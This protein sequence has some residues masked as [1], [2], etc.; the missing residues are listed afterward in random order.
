METSHHLLDQSHGLPILS[1]AIV[2]PCDDNSLT[3]ACQAAEQE[4]INPILIGPKSRIQTV[5]KEEGLNIENYEIIDT[6]HSHDSAEIAVDLCRSGK[7]QALMKGSLHTDELILAVIHK[8]RGIRT[9]RRLSHIFHFDV[10]TYHKPLLITDAAVNVEPDLAE[11]QIILI[12]AIELANAIGI[13]KP[14]VAILQ[15]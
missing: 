1:V 6:Q 13:P 4:L 3:G 11:K 15:L 2:H 12:N 5:A 10:P 14:K 7:A 9:E 8:E